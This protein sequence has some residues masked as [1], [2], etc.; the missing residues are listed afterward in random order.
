MNEEL[1]GRAA[2]L[3]AIRQRAEAEMAA[4]G[5]DATLID[6]VVERFY[7]RIREHERLG[8]V[9]NARLDGRWTDHLAKMKRFWSAIAFKSG[10]YGGKPVQAHQGIEGMQQDLFQ[11]W[12][13]L[14]RLT[15]EDTVPNE[16]ARNW[17][18][19]TAERIAKSLILSLFYNPAMDDPAGRQP[20]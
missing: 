1:V 20:G 3:D 16:A 9:F 14:F 12:L 15:L 11:D 8:P 10:A 4:I 18:L 17:F 6:T 2:Q 13:A 7:G 19:T 5:I